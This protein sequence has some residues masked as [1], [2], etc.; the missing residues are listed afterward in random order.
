MAWQSIALTKAADRGFS[1]GQ[2]R[3][4]MFT[5]FIWDKMNG[6]GTKV[7][8]AVAVLQSAEC[9]SPERTRRE[10]KDV[11][12]RLRSQLISSSSILPQHILLGGI[13]NSM[14]V[15]AGRPSCGDPYGR[16]GPTHPI[17][18]QI[19]LQW[20]GR[21]KNMQRRCLR[22]RWSRQ[23]HDQIPDLSS[24]PYTDASYLVFND[25][26]PTLCRLGITVVLLVMVVKVDAGYLG[27]LAH[28]HLPR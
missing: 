27:S 24:S 17:K 13:D 18:G 2:K 4:C 7:E 11:L 5:C 28:L 6:Y 3:C 12:A 14:Q 9:R 8:K 22:R 16:E 23:L 20:Y 21:Q 1:T 25:T 10:G 15:P 19:R 26:R